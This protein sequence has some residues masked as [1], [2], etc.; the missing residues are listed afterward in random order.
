MNKTENVS[1]SYNS[2]RDNIGRNSRSLMSIME[3]DTDSKQKH[4][5]ELETI[6]KTGNFVLLTI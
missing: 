3:N 6:V 1:E 4:E 2:E 5:R